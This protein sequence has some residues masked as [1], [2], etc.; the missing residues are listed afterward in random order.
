MEVIKSSG[1]CYDCKKNFENGFEIS[2][3]RKAFNRI[4]LCSCCACSM[5]SLLATTFVPKS[6]KNIITRPKK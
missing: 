4:K 3:N 1:I 5:Y 6:P 2:F